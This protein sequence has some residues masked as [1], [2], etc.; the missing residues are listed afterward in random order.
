MRYQLKFF[1]TNGSFFNENN[2]STLIFNRS[3]KKK[4]SKKF[5]FDKKYNKSELL[6]NF[7]KVLMEKLDLK[8]I[9]NSI[10]ILKVMLICFAIEKS[11]KT[12]KEITIN[13]KNLSLK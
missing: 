8:K 6:N 5:S 3:N 11:V 9:P 10:D 12:N 7:I 13:Y 1:G 4:K 2:Q